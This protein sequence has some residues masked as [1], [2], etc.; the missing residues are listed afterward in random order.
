MTHSAELEFGDT[1]VTKTPTQHPSSTAFVFTNM[2]LMRHSIILLGCLF[3]TLSAFGQK[4]KPTAPATRPNAPVALVDT[5][6]SDFINILF[7]DEFS[8]NLTGIDTIKRLIGNVELNQDD[9][10]LFCDSANILNS[11][12]VLAQGHFILQQGDSTTI[13]SDS[14]LYRADTK[15]ADLY[16]DVSLVKGQQKLFTDHLT[17]DANT[18]IATYLTGATLTDD[19]TFLTSVKGYYHA[20]NDDVFFREKVVVESPD[21]SLRTDTLKFN[22][23]SKVVTFVAP[24]LI[25][26]DTARIY[27]ESGNYDIPNKKGI[28]NKNPQYLKNDQKAWARRMEYDG[29]KEEIILAGD[30]HFL[31]STTTA[32]ADRIIYNER[33]G[34]TIL[35]GHAFVKDDKRIITGDT[36]VYNSKKGTYSTRGRSH[37]ED[38]S[39]VLDA[40]KLDYDKEREMGIAV[41]NVIWQDTTERLT[42]VCEFAEHSKQKNYLKA[43][44]GKYGRPLLIKVIDGDSLYVSADT[45]MSLKPDT[46]AAPEPD[47]LQII[48]LSNQD[49]TTLDSTV[50]PKPKQ[51]IATKSEPVPKKSNEPVPVV[52]EKLFELPSE[53]DSLKTLPIV[54]QD[55]VLSD[56]TTSPN[57]K[58]SVVN[59]KSEDDRI[60][61]AFHDVRIFKKDLQALCDSLS[62]SSV[63]SMFRLFK[64][65]II[66]SDTSQFTA[67]TVNIQLANDKIDRIFLR[68]NSF[69]VNSPDEFFFN[70]IKGKNSIAMFDSSELRRVRVVGNAES[71]YYALDD[72][73]AYIGVNKTVC[74]EMLIYFGDN[75]VEGIK[76]Y[77]KP[78]ATLFPM[79]KA[80]HEGLKMAGFSWQMERRPGSVEDLLKAK[81]VVVVPV[82]APVEEQPKQVEEEK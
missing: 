75:E 36:V 13:F 57:R 22:A 68:Q 77:I 4:G 51:K 62:Y 1:I 20:D 39:Q 28:F 65:P 27:T 69:I 32:T 73:K 64:A 37:V 59:R 12:R 5:S 25:V 7:S 46:L 81:T 6:G 82:V 8:Y 42:V 2:K 38:G 52:P 63:D 56:S 24:T 17:Y 47:S 44:G 50:A 34:V 76:F 15:I 43:S 67:D 78:K 45:L 11:Q 10:Y 31:D 21:F 3:F 16:R 60:I 66:W 14:A 54:P 18:K 33:L 49:S 48:E 55:S 58:S 30:A 61:L 40:N 53:N 19:S 74:S 72:D 23:R 71:V 80:D 70:Q 35:Q 29:N 79:K 26:Q 41:G 9:V